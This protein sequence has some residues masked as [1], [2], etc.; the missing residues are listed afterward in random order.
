MTDQPVAPRTSVS[1]DIANRTHVVLESPPFQCQGLS[2][3]EYL[4]RP[5]WEAVYFSWGIW[6]YQRPPRDPEYSARGLETPHRVQSPQTGMKGVP[7]Q[8][9]I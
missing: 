6:T 3:S 4:Q 8:V 2:E 7:I 5:N 1:I 9:T